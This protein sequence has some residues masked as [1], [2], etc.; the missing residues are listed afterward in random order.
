VCQDDYKTNQRR[1][2]AGDLLDAIAMWERYMRMPFRA[3]ISTSPV[4]E[5]IHHDLMAL[6]KN[7]GIFFINWQGKTVI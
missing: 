3:M 4:V 1:K 6:T 2:V 5:F 7:Y